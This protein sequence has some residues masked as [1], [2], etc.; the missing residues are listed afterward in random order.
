MKFERAQR[1]KRPVVS[2]VQSGLIGIGAVTLGVI[3]VAVVAAAIALAIAL[4]Y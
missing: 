3:A 1:S 2:L 4:S